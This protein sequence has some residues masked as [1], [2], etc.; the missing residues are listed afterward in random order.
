[1]AGA[2]T[3]RDLMLA[4]SVSTAFDR[5]GW[6]FELKYD[7]YC[8]LA[9][10]HG[11]EVRLLSRRGNDLLPCFPE[12]AAWLRELPDMVLDGGIGRTPLG[13][14]TSTCSGSDATHS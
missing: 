2:I 9:I 12:I 10:R 8:T 7:G 11:E 13:S 4:T 5:P 14:V 1:M 6:L 3:H